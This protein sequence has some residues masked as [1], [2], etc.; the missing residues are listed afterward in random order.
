NGDGQLDLAAVNSDSNDVSVLLGHGDGTFAAPL[1]FPVGFDFPSSLVA[2]DVN[3]DGRLD[4][5]VDSGV[6]VLLGRGDGTFLLADAFGIDTF[7]TSAPFFQSGSATQAEGDFNGD[8]L[9]DV[10]AI[11]V[12]FSHL[13]VSLRQKDGTLVDST[14]V[15]PN[16]IRATPL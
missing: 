6:A 16:P 9:Q 14:T 7:V 3:G 12:N 13:T 5:I 4:L 1:S 15:P 8:G 2:G 10:A 11:N